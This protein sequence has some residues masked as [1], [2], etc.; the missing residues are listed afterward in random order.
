VYRKIKKIKIKLFSN[1]KKQPA[2]KGMLLSA[3]YG[4][5]RGIL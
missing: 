3:I 1:I 2:E 4:V 5:I